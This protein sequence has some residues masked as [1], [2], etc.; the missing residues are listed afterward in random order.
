MAC[1]DQQFFNQIEE[2]LSHAQTIAKRTIAEHGF[3][4]ELSLSP[5]IRLSYTVLKRETGRQRLKDAF[6]Q[7]VLKELRGRGLIVRGYDNYLVITK[8]YVDMGREFESLSHLTESNR[9]H[10]SL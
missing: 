5:T 2:Q 8:P 9:K 6:Y 10:M 1:K 4:G 3:D 7:I